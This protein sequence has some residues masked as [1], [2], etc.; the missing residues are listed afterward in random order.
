MLM[1]FL[2]ESKVGP[3]RRHLAF[4]EVALPAA[5]L[6]PLDLLYVQKVPGHMLGRHDGAGLEPEQC[7]GDLDSY[8]AAEGEFG[9]L[10]DF[11][12]CESPICD[13]LF[14]KLN[15]ANPFVLNLGE[16]ASLAC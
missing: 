4:F 12:K 14:Y 10:G 1:L 7:G 9:D 13:S 2:G 8:G 16:P 11:P 5:D 15:P 3:Q 6:R